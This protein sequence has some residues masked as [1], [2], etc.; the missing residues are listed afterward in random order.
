[1]STLHFVMDIL[2]LITIAVLASGYIKLG[3]SCS[4]EFF[5]GFF[6]FAISTVL[7]AVDLFV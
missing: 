2:Y 5:T 3:A 1:M 6:F 7:S 4:K